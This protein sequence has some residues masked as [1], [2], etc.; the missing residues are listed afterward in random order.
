MEEKLEK[1]LVSILMN[2]FNGEKYLIEA[3]DSVYSQTYSNWEI[4]FIDNCS[5]DNT[6]EIVGQYDKKIKYHKTKENLE[7]GEARA[8][9]L[10]FCNGDFL[11]FLDVDDYY[12][13]SKLDE[14]IYQMEINKDYMMCYSGG[15]FMNEEGRV[16]KKFTPIAKSGFVFPQQL[17]NYEINMQT[18]IIRNNIVINFDEKLEYSPDFDLFMQICSE[19]EVGVIEKP[20]VKYRR[21]KNSL[22]SSKKNR[23]S[24]EIKYTLDKI[25]L[26]HPRLK[27]RYKKEVKLAYAKASYYSALYLIDIGQRHKAIR[28]LSKYKYS[29]ILFFFLFLL[30]FFPSWIWNQIHRLK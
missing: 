19:N 4:I 16:T 9:G 26:K 11:C 20:L 22:S 30:A 18:V 2:C 14:Q 13:P 12:F 24:V 28:A 23:W 27:L 6:K 8:F 29:S 15:F 17:I 5:T 21:L 25:F 10:E 1:P 7:L 3:I